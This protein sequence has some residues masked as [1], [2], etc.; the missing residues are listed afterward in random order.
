MKDGFRLAGT[1]AD[2]EVDSRK[3]SVLRFGEEYVFAI[4]GKEI[5]RSNTRHFQ[6]RLYRAYLAGDLDLSGVA[7]FYRFYRK[8]RRVA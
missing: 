1:E 3:R 4:D 2:I 7:E 5:F 8:I 6:G